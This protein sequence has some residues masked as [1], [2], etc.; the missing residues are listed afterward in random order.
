M[1]SASE[2]H[3]AVA[4]KEEEHEF[5]FRELLIKSLNY[6]P[7]FIVFLVISLVSAMV[8]IHYQTPV[9]STSIKLLLKALRSRSGSGQVTAISDQ[10]LPQVYFTPKTTMA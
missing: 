1:A 6:V 2:N 3:R 7:L 9:Y 4:A 8:Y 5:S 10:V